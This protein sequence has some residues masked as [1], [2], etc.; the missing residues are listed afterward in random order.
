MTEVTTLCYIERG[1]EVL[2]LHRTKKKNDMNE[3]KWLGVGGHCEQG[4]SPEDCVVREAAEETGLTLESPSF[5]GIIT[6]V[7]KDVT[8][9]MMLFTADSFTGEVGECSEGEL[10][11]IPKSDIMSLSLWEGDRIF[12][13]LLY[14]NEP[15][16]SL[17]LVYDD[18]GAL[19]KA[20]LNGKVLDK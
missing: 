4:E 5:R 16:F 20:V 14:D 10:K 7:Y 17:K 15:F 11:W 19:T 8:E 2:M 18:S 9:Y 3:G 1:E 12:L 6:F 13:K